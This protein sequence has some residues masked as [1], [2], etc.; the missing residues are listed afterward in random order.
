MTFLIGLLCLLAALG[1][2]VLIGNS[3]DDKTA[4]TPPPQVITV[5]GAA[6]APAATTPAA[7]T[8]TTGS[9]STSRGASGRRPSRPRTRTRHLPKRSTGSAASKKAVKDLNSSSGADYQK[10]SQKLPKQVGTSGK[11][12]PKDDKPAGGGTGFQDIG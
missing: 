2:G 9:S 5:G 3:G 8:S 11:A 4:A 10:K 1:V 7:T 6:A 12:P